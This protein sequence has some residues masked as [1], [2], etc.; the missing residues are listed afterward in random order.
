MESL[1]DVLR[2]AMDEKKMSIRKLESAISAELGENQR[3][4]RNLIHEYLAGKR[5]PTYQAAVALSKVLGLNKRRF[6]LLT[7]FARQEQRKETERERFL[8]FC[9]QARVTVKE[10]DIENHR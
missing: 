9:K 7:Y 2:K 4:S 6:L 8:E 10:E 1:Q 3:V 5:A